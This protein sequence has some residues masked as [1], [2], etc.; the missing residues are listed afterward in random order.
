MLVTSFNQCEAYLLPCWLLAALLRC[1]KLAFI[2]LNMESQ[3]KWCWIESDRSL[4]P[5]SLCLNR[6]ICGCWKWKR[7]MNVLF[8]TRKLT[9]FNAYQSSAH[10]LE[11]TSWHFPDITLLW[12]PPWG[13]IIKTNILEFD[14]EV[15][16]SKLISYGIFFKYSSRLI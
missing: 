14:M 12:S 1:C 3:S 15:L 5:T 11:S 2:S 6:C 8:R 10:N 7:V 9:L 13:P 16:R 4:H